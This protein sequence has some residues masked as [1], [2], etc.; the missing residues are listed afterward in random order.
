MTSQ[1]TVIRNAVVHTSNGEAPT[2]TTVV[3]RDGVFVHV[4][5][6][7]TSHVDTE[8]L[9]EYD[10]AGRSVVPGLVDAHTH[11]AMVARSA[12][13]KR[14]PWTH[15][16]QE[17]LAFVRSYAEAHP[18]AEE[19]YL[20]FEY[21]PGDIFGGSAPTKELLDTAVSD[22][23]CLLQ[24]HGEHEH[25]VNS[26]M[27][28][29]MGVTK[30][31]PDPSPP[32][33]T[34]VRDEA[35]EPTGQ[36]REMAHTH[37]LDAM[38]ARLGW[39]PPEHLSPATI[40]PFLRF[41]TEH[42]VCAV[43]D[44]LAEGEEM[45]SSVAELD[46]A[47]ELNLLYEGALR[48]TNATDLPHVIDEVQ[49]LDGI[50]GNDHVRVRTVKLFL[51][52][53]NELGNSAVLAPLCT[54]IDA[55]SLGEIAQTTE[56]LAECLS[57]C[58]ERGTDIHIH[59]VGDRA[60]RS[61][62]DAVELVRSRIASVGGEWR[63]QVTFAHCELVDPADM[64]RP[65][66]LGI[67]INWTAH[68]SGGYFGE[69]ARPH[70]GDERWD[71]MYRFNEIAEAGGVVTLSSDV[72]TAYESHRANPFF[73][74]HVAA[75]RVDPEFPLNPDEFPRS[76]RPLPSGRLARDLLLAGY[77]INGARQLRLADRLGSIEVGKVANLVVVDR[78]PTD[79]LQ[80]P[81]LL[82]VVIEAVMF[83]GRIVSGALP[84]V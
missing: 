54:H 26:R 44:A 1:G 75:T 36:L 60:F 45:V 30:D 23:P 35:G 38:Y 64:A 17:I 31:T 18:A 83:E 61:A 24:D 73:G 80:S 7:D 62:C 8:G 79:E 29:L 40:G 48:F 50:Y 10:I 33:Q 51:D 57:I 22:R 34:F 70:L 49:R 68:W 37:F 15:D 77:S 66:G 52:G 43:L 4:G 6:D 63:T 65:A 46:R 5:G 39:S 55:A 11:P 71:R 32:L 82:D 9:E 78:D 19:P 2:A 13:H 56:Q 59:M 21:Y 67:F 42:G 3:I 58:N 76:E 27:L 81:A 84:S 41:L 25:W 16:L 72:V 14:L 53:T 28:E 20:Y 12:W 69:G 74:M 47:G